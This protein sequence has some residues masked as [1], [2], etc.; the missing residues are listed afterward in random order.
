MFGVTCPSCGAFVDDELVAR[1]LSA[2]THFHV[3]LRCG[4]GEIITAPHVVR[5][6]LSLTRKMIAASKRPSD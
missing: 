6:Q 5:C 1:F 4:C 3:I 2:R